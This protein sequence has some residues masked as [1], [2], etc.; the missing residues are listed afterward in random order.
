[1]TPQEI[2]N[3]GMTLR[4]AYKKYARASEI[5]EYQNKLPVP[6]H[7]RDS[8]DYVALHNTFSD[9]GEAAWKW[10]ATESSKRENFINELLSGILIAAGFLSP[11]S[12]TDKPQFIPTDIWELGDIKLS[13]SEIES[14][15]LKFEGI[16]IIK[17]RKNK[18]IAAN[19][20][21]KLPITPPRPVGRP[22]SREKIFAAYQELKSENK[23][24][25]SQPMTHAYPII[26]SR[27]FYK[28]KTE[29]GFQN[30]AIRLAIR[31]D[32]QWEADKLKSV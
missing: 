6:E 26:R 29:K 7:M 24:D 27:L 15:S 11:R 16:R 23:I 30:E 21:M 22:G 32:F 2:I 4:A 31:D 12:A 17:P 10:T 8:Q 25:F 13:K 14:G 19:N 9:I 18:T 20:N 3:S 5:G 1:M 28:Y